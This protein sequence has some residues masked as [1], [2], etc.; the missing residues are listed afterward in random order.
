[1]NLLKIIPLAALS[2]LAAAC[3]SIGRPQGGPRD[4]EP[5]VFVRSNPSPGDTGV[6]RTSFSII[7][8]ENVSLDDAFNKVVIS[9]VQIQAPTISANG[10]RVSVTLR[11]TLI[12]NSTYTIDF[13]DA[14]KD[15]NEGNV[16]DGYALD[17]STGSVVDSMRISGLVLQA[18]NLEPAQGMLVAAYS[19]TA[20]SAIRTLAPDRIARTNQLGQFTIRNL[21]PGAYRV[22]ALKDLNRDFHWDRSEDVAFFDTLITPSIESIDVIDTLYSSTGADSLISRRGRRYLPNDVLLTW[23][24][25]NYKA[26]YLKDYRRPEKRKAVLT[27][28]APP[29]SLPRINIVGT[30]LD[31]HPA[32]DWAVEQINATGDSIVLWLRDSVALENDSLMLSVSYRKPDSLERMEWTTDTLRFFYRPPKQSKKA[33]ADTIPPKYDVLKVDIASSTQDVHLP[34]SFTVGQPLVSLDTA[35]V[36]I[37]M[38]VDTLWKPVDGFKIVPDSLDPLLTRN[39]AI[40]WEPGAKY[41]VCIDS[42][43]IV[44]IYNEHNPGVKREITV[45]TLE[46]YA[47]LTFRLTG[48]D[49]TAIVELLSS[50]DTPAATAR[51]ADGKAVFRFLNPGTYYAR[52]F[53]DVNGDGKWTTGILDSIQPEEVAYFPK[54]LDLKRNWDLEQDWDIYALPI[55]QQ[56]PKAILKNKPKLKRGE[57]QYED[58]EEFVDEDPMLGYP[59]HGSEVDRRRNSRNGNRNNNRNSMG[60]G[61]RGGMGFGGGRNTNIAR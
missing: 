33:E 40:K 24:N 7:F 15:L 21:A 11:D 47:N 55:D 60:T 22:Y 32:R 39:I 52:V 45:R 53:F 5:P 42:A 41:R 2:L 31:A 43:A 28:G 29:D 35:A 13:G 27:F 3:A 56:K 23:F 49:S 48:A 34:L 17:F 58:D 4:E 59:G 8:N 10:R 12:P 20:D 14:I 6:R 37:E 57:E 51:M 16:L 1:M 9:P 46:D 54:K 18:S 50:S 25:E 44:G 30:V 61:N 26:Q 19:N 36:H 38:Q